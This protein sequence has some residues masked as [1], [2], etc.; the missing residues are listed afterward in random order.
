MKHIS[1]IWNNKLLFFRQL[2]KDISWP[3]SFSP[4]LIFLLYDDLNYLLPV[5]QRKIP[6]LRS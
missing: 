3:F 1:L 4:R 6:A 5:K 2:V